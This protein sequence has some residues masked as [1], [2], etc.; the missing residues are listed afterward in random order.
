M[1]PTLHQ[2]APEPSA[3][4]APVYVIGHRNPDTDAICSAI[5]YAEFLRRTN[6]PGAIAACCGA[7]NA[8]TRFAL[9]EAGLSAPRLLLDARPTAGQVCRRD[10]VFA[11]DD[12]SVFE[13]INRM[14]GRSFRSLPVIDGSGRL[15]GLVSIQNA[16]ELL[17]PG[18]GDMSRARIV[19]T[20]LGR[21][22]SVLG[23]GVQHAGD[24]ER[25]ADFVVT[26]AAL[27]VEKFTERL[28][29][30]CPQDLV[31]V[32]GD[33]PSVQERAIA[34]G[35]SALIV[36]GG[37]RLAEPTL[38]RARKAAI[39][40]L[41]S[42]HDTATTT[43]LI[44]CASRVTNV[45]HREFESFGERT[46]LREAAPVMAR[47]TGQALFPVLDDSRAMVG[48]LAR[49]DLVNPPRTRL[50]LVDHNEPGQAVAGAAEAEIVEIL[51][52]HR[53][54]A[55]FT[56][57]EPIRFV[58]EPVGSTCTLVARAWREA[59]L[60]PPEPMALC[61]A[62]G[63]ISDTLHLKSPTTTPLD[64]ELLDWLASCL[65]RSLDVFARRFFETGS[66]LRASTPADVVRGDLKQY[67]EHEWRIAVAQVEEVGLEQFWNLKSQLAEALEELNRELSTDFA[68]LLVT[69]IVTQNS[70]LL[71]E[72][73]AR[74]REA[75]GYPQIE[76]G[77]FELE[78]I[79]SRK[80]QL[81]PYIMRILSETPK[82]ALEG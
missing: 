8:R 54:G 26:V 42:P 35:V 82:R 56:S 34:H 29:T 3:P 74:L 45:L 21:M 52:H 17:L 43:L 64:R 68:C 16:L 77:L 78:N 60:R 73:D 23:A 32:A 24:L 28:A 67:E 4:Q 10:I 12:E 40:V 39:A 80:K 81:L 22:A 33:R 55:G 72:G 58:N 2:T 9:E 50:V 71:V 59:G 25:E 14:R 70:V 13:A 49:S 76:P 63:M 75:V 38:H 30:Y 79:V 44:K 18:E 15:A 36:T 6:E 20:C 47:N 37:N 5:A 61:M 31:V 62:A 66:V 41:L 48:V 53:L 69:D 27:S 51:D 57:R 46:P 7:P 19:R 65:E 1:A 11:R